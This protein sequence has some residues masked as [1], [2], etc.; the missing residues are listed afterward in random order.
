MNRIIGIYRSSQ[1]S[2]HY[3]WRHWFI[4]TSYDIPSSHHQRRLLIPPPSEDN[5][6]DDDDDDEYNENIINRLHD[7]NSD[8]NCHYNYDNLDNDADNT[9]DADANNDEE[10]EEDN[11]N[12][13]NKDD[14]EHNNDVNKDEEDSDDDDEEDSD[15]ED[16][17]D[18]EVNDLSHEESFVQQLIVVLGPQFIVSYSPVSRPDDCEVTTLQ[19]CI[20]RQVFFCQFCLVD[21]P[22]VEALTFLCSDCRLEGFHLSL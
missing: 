8:R 1:R 19:D 2:E 10:E 5:D 14:H 7:Y 20:G 4:A 15:N 11:D 13:E 12:K 6:N 16:S 3:Q 22:L 9:D 21:V 18:D 17:A